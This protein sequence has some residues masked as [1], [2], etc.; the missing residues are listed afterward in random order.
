MVVGGGQQ[1]FVYTAEP[2]AVPTKRQHKS[3]YRNETQLPSP[4]NAGGEEEDN[5]NMM[6]SNIMF[7]RRVVRGSTYAAQLI[8]QSAQREAER[9]RRDHERLMRAEALRRRQEAEEKM[10]PRAVPPVAG[11]QHMIIQTD[12]FLEELTDRPL[13][14]E[15]DTQTDAQMDRPPPP[16]FVPAK[17]GT[18]ADTQVEPGELFNFDLEVDPI[19]EV[20]VGKTLELSMIELL[21]EEELASIRQRQKLF[22]ETRD[23]EL[24]E[25]QRLEAEGKRKFAEKQRR[26]KQAQE[27]R[28]QQE[29]VKEKVAARAFA[30]NYLTAINRDV[31]G[32]LEAEGHFEDPL[33]REVQDLFLTWLTDSVVQGV[34]REVA[35]RSTVD[36]VISHAA[37]QTAA[38][39]RA[40]AMQVREAR[41][42]ELEQE[43]KRVLEEQA[44]KV[45]EEEMARKALEDAEKAAAEEGGTGDAG[46]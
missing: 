39:V 5:E 24:A 16:L 29:E 14:F 30:K 10:Q 43:R 46:D 15:K 23:A 38:R 20:L 3:K 33:R 25:V 12:D 26:L 11:R 21:E 28:K 19:L 6:G 40:Q 34:S 44:R 41:I 9:L 36:G 45:L 27:Y 1:A 31:F 13:E 18:D 2:Q 35:A 4:Q 37:V 22:S 8:T 17:S 32:G 7:D 42:A